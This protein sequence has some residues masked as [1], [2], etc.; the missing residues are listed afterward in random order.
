MQ[1]QTGLEEAMS[2]VDRLERSRLLYEEAVFGGNQDALP[3]AEHDLDA[4]E[5]DLALARGRILHARY[6]EERSEPPHELELF[7]RAAELYHQLADARGEGEA[8]FWVGTFHQV[9]RDDSSAALPFLERSFQLATEAGDKLTLSYA[10]R[11]LAFADMAA[12]HLDLARERFEESLRLRRELGFMP[13]VA[14][15]VLALAELTA[16]DRGRDEA[17]A[18]LDEA[19]K[20]AKASGAQRILQYINQ[21]RAELRTT[22]S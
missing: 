7:E 17:L 9:V 21:A 11:H 5:A 1:R 13:G 20:V 8:L 2:V 16:Q 4:V 18:L 12:G 19:T 15:A 14:A 22:G 3:L 10:V 6:L